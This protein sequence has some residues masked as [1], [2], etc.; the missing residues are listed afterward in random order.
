MQASIV[1]IA[2]IVSTD[3]VTLEDGKKLYETICPMLARGEFIELDFQGVDV[4]A[5]P[6]FNAGI[7]QLFSS[8]SSKTLHEHLS[9]QNLDPDG[10]AVL[11]RVIDHAREY[12]T[13]EEYR[14]AVTKVFNQL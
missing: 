8:F 9:V 6:F 3:C 2:E 1:K 12:Y 13:N 5:T 4:Y 14:N 11:R 10:K 7:G